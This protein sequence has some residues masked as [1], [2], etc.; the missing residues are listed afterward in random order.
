MPDRLLLLL[1]TLATLLSLWTSASAFVISPSWADAASNPCSERSWQLL[2]W[3]DDGKCYPIFERGPCP[4]TQELAFDAETK[5]AQCRCPK[6]LILW[7]QT[8]R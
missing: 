7:P 1:P 4:D 2:L 3:P 6:N 8:S 5:R